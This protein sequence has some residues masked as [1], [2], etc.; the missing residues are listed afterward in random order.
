M[1]AINPSRPFPNTSPIP[2]MCRRVRIVLD[3]ERFGARKVLMIIITIR[4]VITPYN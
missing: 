1:R 4:R 3:I 2:H